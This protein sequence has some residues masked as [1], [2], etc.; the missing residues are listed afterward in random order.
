MAAL[1]GGVPQFPGLGER[2]A[3][4]NE[5]GRVPAVLLRRDAASAA[6]RERDQGQ[7][8]QPDRQPGRIPRFPLRRDPVRQAELVWAALGHLAAGPSRA[9]HPGSREAGSHRAEARDRRGRRGGCFREPARGGDG[10]QGRGVR[11]GR[12][13]APRLHRD[14]DARRRKHAVRIPGRRGPVLVT[15]GA[16]PL[17]GAHRDA[18]AGGVA[19]RPRGALRLSHHR[20]P[21]RQALPQR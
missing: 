11:P 17:S 20:D 12:R 16:E 8:R 10:P 21:R 9:P 6:R 2:R 1:R 15:A 14:G 7:G 4:R 18:A 5:R 19:R 13:F 3:H